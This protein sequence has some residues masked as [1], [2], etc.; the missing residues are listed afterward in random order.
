MK[1]QKGVVIELFLGRG[2]WRHVRVATYAKAATKRI[3]FG[4][5]AGSWR[6]AALFSV[7]LCVCSAAPVLADTP[8]LAP[9][10]E[11]AAPSPSSEELTSALIQS[12]AAARAEQEKLEEEWD[13]PQAESE[14]QMSQTAFTG[15]TSVEAQSLLLTTFP[16]QVQA[17]NADPARVLSNLSIEKPLGTYGALVDNGD[18]ESAIIESSVPVESQAGEGKKAPVDLS[19]EA[20]GDVFV[21]ANPLSEVEL[22][23]S[24]EETIRLENGVGV[25]L[26]ADHPHEAEQLGDMSLFYPETQTTTDTVAAPL[27]GGVELLEQIRSAESPEEFRYELSLPTAAALRAR[28][29]GGAEVVSGSGDV[30]EE[31]PPPTAVDAQGR[32]VLVTMSVEGESLVVEVSHRSLEVAYPVLLDPSISDPLHF[33]LGEWT[34]ASNGGPYDLFNEGSALHVASRGWQVYEPN[35]WAHL[36]HRAPG[37]TGYILEGNFS[38]ISF[39]TG[40]NGTNGC[41]AR[42]PHGYIGLFDDGTG[43]YTYQG[44]GEWWGGNSFTPNYVSPYGDPNVHRAMVGVGVGSYQTWIKCNHEMFVGGVTLLESDPDNPWIK[45]VSGVPSGWFDPQKAGEATIV[46]A[47]NGFGVHDISVYDGE[48]TNH[49]GF[50]CSGISGSRC[51]GERSWTVPPPYRAGE[52]TLEVFAE[53]PLGH[54]GKWTTTSKVDNQAPAVELNGQF[55]EATEEVG[56]KGAENEADENKLSFPVYNLQIKATDGLDTPATERQSGVKNIKVYLDGVQQTSWAAQTCATYSCKKEGTYQLKLLELKLAAGEHKL[57]VVAEDQVGHLGEREIEFEYIPATGI[58]DD[59]VMQRF[60][61]PDGEGNEAEEENPVR[62]ELAVNVLNGN[63]VYRQQDVEV[64]GPGADLEV[65]R[66]YNSQLPKEQNTEWG[67]G[68]TLAQTPELE[69]E[70]PKSGPPTDATMVEESGAVEGSVNLPTATGEEKFDKEIQAVVTKEAHGYEVTDASGEA[71]SSVA[72]NEAGEATEIRSSGAAS[73]ELASTGGTLTELAVDDPGTAGGAAQHFKEE[74]PSEPYIYSYAFGG[75]GTGAGNLSGPIDTATD[76]EGNVWVADAG[77]NRVQEFNS[78]GEFVRQFGATGTANGEFTAM[79]GLAFDTKGNLWV[80]AASRVQEFN[81][82]GEYIR[83]F[84][85]TGGAL[86]DVAVDP[87]GHI[88]TLES[89]IEGGKARLQEF[90]AEGAFMTKIE[91][92]SGTGS[93]Q[94]KSPQALAIDASGNFWLA[95]TENNRVEEFTAKG[96]YI[97]VAGSEGTASGQFK[98]PRGIAIDAAGNVWVSDTANNRIQQLSSTGAYLAQVG[99]GGDNNGQFSEPKGLTVDGAGNIWVADSANN[100]VEEI[101]AGAYV[102]QFGG[103]GTGAGNLSGPIDTATDSEGNVWVA[104][105]GHNRVQEFNSKGEFVRQFGATGTANGEFTAMRGLAF[106]TKGNLWVAAASR[107]Q[108]FNSKGEYIRQFAITGGALADVAVDPE[109]HIWTLESTIEGGKAR[110]QEFTAEGAF[111]TKIEIASGTGSGQLKSPQALAID[112]SGNFWL[113][114]TENNRVEEFTAKGAY[115]RVAGSEG[116]ASGQFKKPRGIAIDAAG[117][118]W[119]SDTANNRIQQLSSTGAYLAQVGKGGDNNGQFSEPKGLTVDGAGNIWVADSANNRAQRWQLPGWKSSGYLDVQAVGSEGQLSAPNGVGTDKE[120]NVWVADTAHNRVQEFNSKGEFVRQFGTQGSANGQ[121][122]EP[123]AVAVDNSGNVWVADK[124]NFRVQEFNSKGE[125]IRKFGTAGIGNG[126][127]GRLRGIAVDPENHVWTIELGTEGTGKPRVQE[128]TSEGTY[129]Q[130]FG[131]EGSGVG[132]FI[133][134][135]GIA[136]DANGNVWVADT[137]NRRI[138]GF[139][140]KGERIAKFGQTGSEEGQLANPTGVAIANDGHVWVVDS[141]NNRVSEFTSEG[142]YLR[143]FGAL[144]S[145]TGQVSEPKGVAL[146]P[147]GNVWVAD[148]GN[149]RIGKWTKTTLPAEAPAPDPDPSVDVTASSGLVASVKGEAAGTTSYT[150]SGEKLTA[151]S[152]PKGATAYAYDTEGRLTKVTLPKGTWGEITYDS[153]GRVFSVKTSIEGAEPTTTYFAFTE[154]PRRTVVTP[155]KGRAITYDIAADGSIFKWWNSPKAPTI[156]PLEGSLWFQ[157]GEVHPGTVSPGDQTLTVLA[158]SV[159]GIASIQI[160]A[161]GNHVVAEKICEQNWE[162]AGL[163]CQAVE[164]TFVTETENWPPGILQLEVIVTDR[165]GLVSTQRFWDNIPYTPPPAPGELRPP[166]FEETKSFRES[167]GLDLDIAGNERAL[168][169]QVF[170]LIATWHDANTPSGQVARSS[171]ESWGVPLRSSDIEEMEYRERYIDQASSAIPAWV[172][173]NGVGSA[174]AG[175][176]VDHRAGGIIYV[177]FTAAQAERVSALQAG[178]GLMAPSRIRPFPIPPGY[179]LSYLQSLEL[180]VV[181][182]TGAPGSM[183]GARISIEHNRVEVGATNVSE[184]EAFLNSKFGAAAP[185]TVFYQPVTDRPAY[186]RIRASATGEVKSAEM[187]GSFEPE[188]EECSVGW[189]AWDRGGTKPDGTPLYRHFITTAGHCFAPGTEVKQWARDQAGNYVWERT[190]GYVRRYASNIHPSGFATDAEAIRVEDATIVPRLIRR[191]DS[192][193]TR[194]SGST[195]VKP[196]M[197]VCRMGSLSPEVRC[198]GIEWPPQCERWNE[199]HENGNP[200]ICTI[201]TEIPIQFGDSGGPFWERDTNKAVGT[202]TGGGPNVP[203]AA[204]GGSWFT[205]VE[206]IPGYAEIPGSLSALGVDGEPLHIVEWKP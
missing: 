170:Q 115:I 168:N 143:Q 54:T 136:A 91:I 125:Y 122:N 128:F 120:G 152:G 179:S 57:K 177:G 196:G 47:D 39:F 198:R 26:S 127:F 129:L 65:E 145:G 203:G 25:K 86:A 100:R 22:P 66:I 178:A 76:S 135:L 53:D 201:E 6:W 194:I 160:V 138:Q 13:T 108:E 148:T 50:G 181:E 180:A 200:I 93:G 43:K 97:R 31:V 183:G 40:D 107:V 30:I 29:D 98:K 174:Y 16:D 131:S 3:G 113:A 61:L 157:R 146:D 162:V 123:W 126:Q 5:S 67:A 119:V 193:F 140:P 149:N 94:L 33:N 151:V 28:S 158:K 35:T 166:T 18:G 155:A 101:A 45:S 95:D 117:N 64:T 142:V 77:H 84:A 62:P 186:A 202:L 111:M 27:A 11:S 161:N 36:E 52:R 70:P 96:A 78:K 105:A 167:F 9:A 79:R 118:V 73:V 153:M 139:N 114:D 206:A 109:G 87:E 21:P 80:A 92:A 116:T 42:E 81:S 124:G 10:E 71:A 74:A 182:A 8:P 112:A 184:V 154:T 205:P 38:S 34:I 69:I 199:V 175:Y 147:T 103:T 104:D 189:G 134:P 2:R 1:Q 102:R 85:I 150:H 41:G 169:D 24:A 106:D 15:V 58:D 204:H 37:S 83:Q 72:F 75:T 192:E 4:A 51:S 68:W 165:E 141:K 156:E 132:Q 185:I 55:A 130:Q 171:K 133:G 144:G 164:K 163:E 82:K 137:G 187:I 49:A 172:N 7:L 191:G 19:L 32:P 12:E 17:L 23:V 88:W 173:A 176:F 44:P 90:T 89:T 197:V 59:Y 99:K 48:V 14:R 20:E 159:E 188:Y 63:L 190:L 46:A 56:K 110:L 195:T 60:P 121:F